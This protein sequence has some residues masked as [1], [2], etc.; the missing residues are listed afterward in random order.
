MLALSE[1]PLAFVVVREGD[2]VDSKVYGD[3]V[4]DRE[5]LDDSVDFA[6]LAMERML[7]VSGSRIDEGSRSLGADVGPGCR[8]LTGD[9]L[10]KNER[11][12]PEPLRDDSPEAGYPF[13]Y[14]REGDEE[15]ADG[16]IISGVDERVL[17]SPF[18]SS[19]LCD[20]PV[21]GV[22]ISDVIGLAGLLYTAAGLK[23]FGFE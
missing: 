1:A 11:C 6:D 21:C 9:E 4:L 3:E 16:D 2:G 14:G 15:A 22:E 10:D 7:L 8:T 12:R 13:V 19:P 5:S 18:V 23:V 17:I 20:T